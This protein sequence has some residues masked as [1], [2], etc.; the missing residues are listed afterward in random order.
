[1]AA[2]LCIAVLA[3]GA[4]HVL[5]T[6]HA[7]LAWTHTVEHTRWEEDWRVAGTSLAVDEA[8]VR[9]SGAG[10]EPPPDAVWSDGWWRYRPALAP[11]PE[12]ILAN[13]EFAPGYSLCWSGACRPLQTFAA[14]GSFARLAARPC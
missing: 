8:R 14:R 1:M 6:D 9:S 5:P 13:S 11:L 12:V 7:T 2:A 4:V 3:A 10:M